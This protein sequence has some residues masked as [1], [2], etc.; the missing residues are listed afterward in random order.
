MKTNK[1]HP[2]IND[3]VKTFIKRK[4]KKYLIEEKLSSQFSTI[5]ENKQ[6]SV[7]ANEG[8][9]KHLCQFDILCEEFKTDDTIMFTN[10][11]N[12]LKPSRNAY[13]FYKQSMKCTEKLEINEKII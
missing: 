10:F 8:W 9:R 12:S 5:I 2:T 13:H 1:G 11:A 6:F 3:N 7:T 4:K